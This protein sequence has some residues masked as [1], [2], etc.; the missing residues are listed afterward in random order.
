MTMYVKQ[1]GEHYISLDRDR[2][3]ASLSIFHS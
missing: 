2:N 1:R 3:S